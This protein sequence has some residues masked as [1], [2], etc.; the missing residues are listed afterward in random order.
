MGSCFLQDKEV[1][2]PDAR[3]PKLPRVFKPP[4]FIR[5]VW[6]KLTNIFEHI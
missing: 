6:G 3:D 2:I 5:N 4:E 1:Y